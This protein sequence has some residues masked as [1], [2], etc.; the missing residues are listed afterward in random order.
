VPALGGVGAD[1]GEKAD[2][3]MAAYARRAKSTFF[4]QSDEECMTLSKSMRPF[5][6]YLCRSITSL[7]NLR[8]WS[9]AVLVAL[10][11]CCC[12]KWGE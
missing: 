9:R 6:I 8:G 5:E 12:L 10:T 4:W 1:L 7:K 2:I 3:L 11:L